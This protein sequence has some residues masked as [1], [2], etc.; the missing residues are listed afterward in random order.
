ML[1]SAEDSTKK[2]RLFRFR[3]SSGANPP[4][5]TGYLPLLDETHAV[6]PAWRTNPAHQSNWG[7]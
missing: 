1:Q 6:L 2:C 7:V 5:E 4:V 3:P